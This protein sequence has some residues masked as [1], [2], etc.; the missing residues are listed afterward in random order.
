[1]SFQKQPSWGQLR[2]VRRGW[3]PFVMV[4]GALTAALTLAACGSDSAISGQGKLQV[5]TSFYPL[6]YV[7]E[8]IGGDNVEITDLTPAGGDAHDLELS[9]KQANQVA[10]ADVVVYLGDSFQPAVESATASASGLVLDGM[11]VV[12]A[13]QLRQ[14]DAHIWLNPLIMAEIGNQVA[15]VFSE[16][17]PAETTS[18]STNAETFT[19][20]MEDLNKQYQEGLANCSGATLVTSHEAFGY[21]ADAYDLNQVGITGVNPEAEPSPKRLR[22]IAEI[23][24]EYDVTT[25]F[26]E[27]STAESTE[28]KLSDTLGI[29]T[30]QLNPMESALSE[31]DYVTQMEANLQALQQGLN[32]SK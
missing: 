28:S 19:K 20:K 12:S 30:A 26:F 10:Q 9:P 23:V 6:Q 27:S 22:E 11:S 29:G 2:W 7:A 3:R 32:C 8:Q 17:D 24:E 1:M 18:Y 5:V 15:E 16:A 21:L 25:I 31:G 13:D 14:G 4:V